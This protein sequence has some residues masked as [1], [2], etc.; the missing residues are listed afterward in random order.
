MY[1]AGDLIRADDESVDYH[2]T[3]DLGLTCPICSSAVFWRASHIVS[4]G[5]RRFGRRAAFIHYRGDSEIDW[6]QCELR[7]I[8]KEAAPSLFAM[9]KEARKQRLKTFNSHFLDVMYLG[10]MFPIE[11]TSDRRV[12]A[13]KFKTRTDWFEI[14]RGVRRRLK[15]TNMTDIIRSEKLFQEFEEEK[16]PQ[17]QS[18]ETLLNLSRLKSED[19]MS[20]SLRRK[21]AIEAVEFLSTSSGSCALEVFV[22]LAI[23]IDSFYDRRFGLTEV[24][25][26]LSSSKFAEGVELIIKAILVWCAVSDWVKATE[27]FQPRGFR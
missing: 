22:G 3:T 16:T 20:R 26:S 13:N 25:M 6:Q 27:T 11:K 23:S 19:G 4:R 15:D 18:K 9:T 2:S 7:V 24:S 21:I 14:L 5:E 17:S 8:S 1:L 12:A 10:G